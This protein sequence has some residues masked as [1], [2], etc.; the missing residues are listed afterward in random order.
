M[1]IKSFI[2]RFFIIIFISIHNFTALGQKS[3]HYA[4]ITTPLFGYVNPTL[5]IVQA[6]IKSGHKVTYFNVP[7]YQKQIENSGAVFIPYQ[8]TAAS[9]F[10]KDVS[11][12]TIELN[13]LYTQLDNILTE[14]E[15]AIIEFFNK[16][17]INIVIYDQFAVWGKVIAEKYHIPAVCSNPM[18]LAKPEEWTKS[19]NVIPSDNKNFPFNYM[20]SNL[21]CSNADE[22]IAYTSSELQPEFS[23]QENII[24][25]GKRFIDKPISEAVLKDNSLIYI[26]LGT[27]N[28]NFDLFNQLIEFFKNTSYKVI[29][30]VGNNEEMYK[31]LSSKKSRNIEIHKFVDQTKILSEAAIFFTH[32]GANSLYES[33]NATVPIIM[34]PQADEQN[35]NARRA[36][37]L[38]L[39]Y[40]LQSENISKQAIQD[41]FNDMRSN[42]SKYKENMRKLRETFVDSED[43]NA[44][45]S[46]LSHLVT[47]ENSESQSVAK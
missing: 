13:I 30:S 42:W 40:I 36:K 3:L 9:N 15:P 41:A 28:T 4:F 18:L 16:N 26:S 27:V 21:S 1:N 35:L 43:A 44:L 38:Q 7:A 29:I 19:P 2:L 12:K 24:F 45:A 34:I 23:N 5:E 22:I 39:G 17:E 46:D 25:F 33:I 32:V 47:I 31:E 11:S 8:G 20:I 37:E 10:V 14:V 6:L